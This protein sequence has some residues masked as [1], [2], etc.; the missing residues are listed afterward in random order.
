MVV[1]LADRHSLAILKEGLLYGINESLLTQHIS[2]YVTKYKLLYVS[3]LGRV[4]VRAWA[5][6]R[7]R[8]RDRLRVRARAR[9]RHC[10][11]LT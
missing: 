7:A 11:L 2:G 9:T 8:V 10:D 5:R 6:A 1:T 3:N 4:G